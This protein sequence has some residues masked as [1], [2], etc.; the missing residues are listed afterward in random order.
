MPGTATHGT[1]QLHRPLARYAGNP[2]A[3][4]PCTPRTLAPAAAAQQ[5]G[6]AP[7][8]IVPFWFCTCTAEA[9]VT[10]VLS[11]VLCQALPGQ[12]VTTVPSP[13]QGVAMWLLQRRLKVRCATLL[14]AAS[15]QLVQTT[16]CSQISFVALAALA[17]TCTGSCQSVCKYCA[18]LC[19]LLT[20]L[21]RQLKTL[22]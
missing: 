6:I 14:A 20:P 15:P 7:N 10:V 2:R 16:L 4:A 13:P 3:A 19:T 22:S 18:V 21:L 12:V 9:Y 17:H 8:K 11:K 5:T 1:M